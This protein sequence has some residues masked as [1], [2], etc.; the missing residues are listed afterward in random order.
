MQRQSR[1]RLDAM[2]RPLRIGS[3]TLGGNVLLAP[4]AGVT[5]RPFRRLVRRFG[6]ALVYS[7]MI[8]SREMLRQGGGSKRLG[9]KAD[10]DQ[11]PLAVQLAGCDPEIMAEAARVTEARGAAV[12]DINMGCPVKKVVGGLAGSALMR[13][14]D[15]AVRIVA[16]V[17]RAVRVPV[18]LKMRM[19]WDHDSLNAPA[20]ARKAEA[21][22]VQLITV[23]G[24]TRAQLY[25]GRADWAFIR[26]VKDAVRIPVIGN[27]DV[28]APEDAARLLEVSGADGVMIGRGAFGKP[29]FPAQV[30]RF[31]KNGARQADPDLAARAAL[32]HEHYDDLLVYYG[33]DKGLR[34]ARKHLAW[35]AY[36]LSGANAFRAAVNTETDPRRVHAAIARLFAQGDDL[37]QA[38]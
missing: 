24:R 12:I 23:H 14:E 7:E 18:T 28:V 34:I 27:G 38:A 32:L 29:W 5:D 9:V 22:G 33:V 19:G 36:G 20:L 11:A 8:A 13:D 3:L 10:D 17:V 31:L 6:C 37:R 26:R 15:Q 4:M 30:D 16:A 21:A 35:S 1:A 25:T 2:H